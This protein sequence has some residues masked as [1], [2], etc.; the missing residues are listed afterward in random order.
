M[1]R[2]TAALV[3]LPLALS[4]VAPSAAADP[5]PARLVPSPV[6]GVTIDNISNL[7]GIVTSLDRLAQVPTARIVF[8]GFVP[9]TYYE[10]AVAA[11]HPVSYIMGEMLDSY[12][13]RQY[14]V[15]QYRDRARQYVD[16]LGDKVDIWEIGNEINGEWLG[17]RGSV[18]KKMTA[19]Y[20][21]VRNR[22][23]RTA[24]T[25]YYNED[26]WSNPSNEMFVWASKNVPSRMKEGLDYVWIS[27]YEDDCGGRR[28]EWESVFSRLA[29]M[30][31]HSR[32]GIGECGTR[33]A[34]SKA[35]Y[36]R[37]YYGMGVPQ[38]RYVGGYFWWYFKQDMVP[39]TKPLWSVLNECIGGGC[40]RVLSG[41]TP[42]R[43]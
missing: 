9:A 35:D 6:W 19:A 33:K 42:H 25:L 30:F 4:A 29:S 15:K 31:P 5:S 8:D 23:G 27:Y 36:L 18:V 7:P 43:R 24:L 16:A 17:T 12:V 37:R 21:V 2:W 28:P 32:I 1:V 38:N 13:F 22:G 34:E 14:T 41:S 11:I 39:Y 20:D 10:D 3:G 40:S 26:C